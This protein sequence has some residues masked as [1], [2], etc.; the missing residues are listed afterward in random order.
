MCP[1]DHHHGSVRNLTVSVALRYD[2]PAADQGVPRVEEGPERYVPEA[3][4]LRHVL[5]SGHIVSHILA[6]NFLPRILLEVHN[7]RARRQT[8]FI[9]IWHWT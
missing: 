1:T 2:E 5:D 9:V 8:V 7:R 3:Q 6:Y 4:V